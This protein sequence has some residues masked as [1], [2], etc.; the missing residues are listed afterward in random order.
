MRKQLGVLTSFLFLSAMALVGIG[1]SNSRCCDTSPSWDSPAYAE[2]AGPSIDGSSQP[3]YQDG[4]IPQDAGMQVGASACGPQGCGPQGCAPQGQAGNSACG[5]EPLCKPILRCKHPN[6]NELRCQDYII[7]TGRNPK[8]CLLGDQ[9]PLEFDVKACDDVCDVV[10]TTNLPDGVTLIKSCPEA[11]VDG[12]KVTWHFGPMSKGECRTAHVLLKC[13]CEGELCACFCATATP[14]RFCSLLCAKPILVCEKCGPECVAPCDPI[15]YTITV[16]NRGSTTAEDVV[17]TDNLPLEVEH[18]S[19]LR[20]LTYKL[21]CLE[22]CESKQVRICATAVKRGKACNTAIVSAC[23]ADSTSC[24]WCTNIVQCSSEVEK[25][26]PKE[27]MIGKNADYQIVYTNTGD[28]TLT[29]VVVTDYAPSSTSIVT[30]NGAAVN[31]NEAVWRLREVKAGEKVSF[32]ITLTTCTPGCF[33]NRVTVTNCQQCNACT[34]FTTRWRGR[35]ALSACIIDNEGAICVGERVMYTLTVINQGSEADNDVNVVIDFPT[36]LEPVS[37]DGP[38]AGNISGKTV[39]FAPFNNLRPRQ[40]LTYRIEAEA[41][42]SG[43]GRVNA[44]ITSESMR[45][46]LV[47]QGSTVVN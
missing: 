40:T 34:E 11:E 36:E 20:T 6:V 32:N 7:V 4:G 17:V 16:T 14:V 23:N 33:S 35:P 3:F 12:N 26:G 39:K 29:D 8:M 15:N 31:G 22:P 27:V 24:Q 47:Q 2:S 30:A 28:V 5:P 41:R 42:S 19:G 43:D 21:G 9:Y 10:V 44:R 46:P 37:V 45:T 13:E 18:S 38:T 1:C 25:V